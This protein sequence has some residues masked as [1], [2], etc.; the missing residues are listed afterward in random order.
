MAD[1]HAQGR[2]DRMTNDLF[3]LTGRKPMSMYDFVVKL[4]IADFTRSATS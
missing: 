1:L 4:H 3:E 2:Y